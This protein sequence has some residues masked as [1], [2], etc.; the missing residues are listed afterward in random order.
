MSKN[1]IIVGAGEFALIAAEYF[2][3]DSDLD[4]K[5]FAVDSEYMPAQR[6][7]A[8]LP[9]VELGSIT[10]THPPDEYGAFVAIPAT[11]LNRNRAE[12]FG[13][14]DAHGYELVSYISSH[15]FVWH[16]A[17]IGRNT[18]I[19]ENNVIQPF[20]KIGDNCVLWSGNH[21]GHRTVIDDHVFVTSHVVISGFCSIGARSFL[22]V[23]STLNDGI[24]IARDCVVGAAAH[25]TRNTEPELIYV[26]SPARP[27]PNRSSLDIKL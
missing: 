27:V 10:Q 18:F 14:I 11:A 26:G 9:V 12:M 3:H 25:V 6:E 20:T 15:A 2:T 24:T 23:N 19:F 4:V 22:G 21:I 1:I 16:N 8:G 5:A 7:L 17:I 13:R